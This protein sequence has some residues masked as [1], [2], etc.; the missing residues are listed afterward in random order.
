M[1]RDHPSEHL[2]GH[3]PGTGAADN[4]DFFGS[5]ATTWDDKFP[6]DAPLYERAVSE[7]APAVGGVVVDIG[8]GTGR[9]LPFLRT[10]VGVRG[11]VIGL[12]L[13]A[14]MLDVARRRIAPPGGLL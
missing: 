11:L 2:P 10:A 12:D 3:S 14:E 13:T 9:A 1:T 8:C 4:Q 5:R 6:D 7:L